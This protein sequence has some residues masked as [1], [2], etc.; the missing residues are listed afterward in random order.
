MEAE[1][2]SKASIVERFLRAL[3]GMADDFNLEV[4]FENEK[5]VGTKTP[6]GKDVGLTCH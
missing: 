2:A 4:K 1:E 3:P 5:Y 6:K